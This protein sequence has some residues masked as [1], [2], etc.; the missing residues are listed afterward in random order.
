MGHLSEYLTVGKQI[1]DVK[2]KYQN[3]IGILRTI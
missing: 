3:Y 1:T 2:P